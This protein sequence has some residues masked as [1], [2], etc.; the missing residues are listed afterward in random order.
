MKYRGEIDGLR[1]LAVITVILFHAGFSTF[2]GG[3]VG[4]DVFFV[5]SGFLITSIILSD[6]KAGTFSIV[7]FYERRARRILPALFLVL[8]AS[9]VPAWIWLPQSAMVGFCK[10]LLGVSLFGSNFVF[11]SEAGYFDFAAEL[12]PL[13]HTWS[14]AVEEQFYF[15]FPLILVLTWRLGRLGMAIIFL[16]LG[17]MSFWAA[18]KYTAL[19]PHATFFLLP[20]RGWELLLGAVAALYRSVIPARSLEN[21]PK[22]RFV[23][24]VIAS[25]YQIAS[26]TGLAL[27]AA[28]V[29]TFTKDTP[30]PSEYTLAPTVGTVLLILFADPR[31]LVGLLL[32]LKWLV[33][34]GLI[35]YSL[36]LW[37]YPLF[38]FTRYASVSVPGR[39]E[40]SL[41]SLVAVALAYLSWR[42]VERPFRNRQRVG[43][44]AVFA[45]SVVGIIAFGC[46]AYEGVQSVGFYSQRV[47]IRQQQVLDKL[48]R[49]PRWQECLYEET[50]IRPKTPCIYNEGKT[51]WA[52]FGDSHTSE[53]AMALGEA[54]KERGEALKQFSSKEKASFNEACQGEESCKTWTERS[55]EQIVND[56]TIRN[57]VVSYRIH[58]YLFGEQLFAYP[59]LPNDRTEEVRVT[60]WRHYV[61]ALKRLAKSDKRIILVLQAPELRT[62]IEDLVF[63]YRLAPE[64]LAGVSREWWAGRSAYQ[65]ERLNEF[66]SS[67]KIFDPATILCDQRECMA[68]KDG[69]PLY[70]DDNHLGLAGA[71]ILVPHIL[72]LGE[73]SAPHH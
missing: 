29:F 27:V 60:T 16:G 64:N 28:S 20:T 24:F 44:V 7:G 51:T 9:L 48:R 30:F 66:P 50:D 46:V 54:L 69:V 63:Q 41:L 56:P 52:I 11:W 31:T 18:E 70:F 72:A 53:L 38:V 37:H 62:H 71:R 2:G 65:T 13:L 6:K 12:K 43:R 67:V 58:H 34:L 32:S 73:P 68:V 3:F 23:R 39:L 5:I 36:Y 49:S 61:E 42:F 55:I 10:S 45:F 35:S 57:V 8:L 19:Y 59:H 33:G 4:V 14:L 21:A 1:A 15:I 47:A 22:N 26:L 40:F 17:G 25:W